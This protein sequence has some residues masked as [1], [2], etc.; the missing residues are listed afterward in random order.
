MVELRIAGGDGDNLVV[1][2]PG[3]DHCHHAHGP[4]VLDRQGRHRFLGQHQRV[5]RIALAAPSVCGVKP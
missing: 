5:E 4:R 3:I 1:L 2:C